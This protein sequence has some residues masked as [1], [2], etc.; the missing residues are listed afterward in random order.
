MTAC[1][2]LDF[3]YCLK[4]FSTYSSKNSVIT[5]YGLSSP[6]QKVQLLSRHDDLIFDQRY[7]DFS[8]SFDHVAA[9]DEES[10]M[11]SSPK[12]GCICH[13]NLMSVD[14]L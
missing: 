5:L 11:D 8:K 4:V 10:V 13:L 2:S 9:P 7:K 6:L 3:Y 1:L 14:S 12:T